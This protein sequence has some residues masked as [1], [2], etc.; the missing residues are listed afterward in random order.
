MVL[1]VFVFFFLEVRFRLLLELVVLMVVVVVVVD[2]CSSQSLD[3]S[4]HSK[5]LPSGAVNIRL[6]ELLVVMVLVLTLFGFDFEE[7]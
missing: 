3:S 1:A 4:D 6:P 7:R 5:M 2:S